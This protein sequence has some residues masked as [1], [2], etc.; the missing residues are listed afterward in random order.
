MSDQ[1]VPAL[2]RRANRRRA[3]TE[4]PSKSLTAIRALTRM[5]EGDLTGNGLP[6][7][8]PEEHKGATS[9]NI[10][11]AASVPQGRLAALRVR[12]NELV[13]AICRGRRPWPVAAGRPDACWPHR[14]VVSSKKSLKQCNPW[15][16]GPGAE[17]RH[18]RNVASSTA[19]ETG[20]P[21]EHYIALAL[22]NPN[23]HGIDTSD[24]PRRS[25]LDTGSHQLDNQEKDR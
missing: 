20:K 3:R 22:K 11:T 19:I 5:Q 9:S 6:G 16:S 2:G 12:A 10:Q 14:A 21:I 1:A 8:Q 18:L 25:D 23:Y 7:R 13:R 17:L 24:I 15:L 4:S